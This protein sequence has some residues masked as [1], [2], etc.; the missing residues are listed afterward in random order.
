MSKF[1]IQKNLT[2]NL[3]PHPAQSPDLNPIEL[4]WARMKI[5]VEKAHPKTKEELKRKKLQAWNEI[6]L[7]FIRKCISGLSKRMTKIIEKEG[8][9]L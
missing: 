9:L 1:F 4:I 8:N 5:S 3:L 2:P 6:D 7:S